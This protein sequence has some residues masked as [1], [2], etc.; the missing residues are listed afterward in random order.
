[1]AL[2]R[3]VVEGALCPAMDGEARSVPPAVLISPDCG[4][5]VR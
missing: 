1:M 4:E 3:F 2:K 5:G